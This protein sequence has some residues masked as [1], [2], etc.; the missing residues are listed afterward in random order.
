MLRLLTA[1]ATVLVS[2]A[3]AATVWLTACS[4]LPGGPNGTDTSTPVA[5]TLFKRDN[6]PHNS[7]NTVAS[8]AIVPSAF[9][10]AVG[11][12]ATLTVEARNSTG[13]LVTSVAPTWSSSDPT[14]ASVTNGVVQGV[15]TG[16]ALITASSAGVSDT[17]TATVSAAALPV[18]AMEMSPTTAAVIVGQSMPLEASPVAADSSTL[19]GQTITWSSSNS[20]VAAVSSAGAVTGVA[21][22]TAEVQATSSGVSGTV[23]VTVSPVPAVPVA[24]VT[25]T[26]PSATVVTGATV[27]LT[28]ATLDANG[29]ALSGRAVTW[30]SSDQNILT[31]STAGLVKGVA[32]GSATVTATS[33]GQTG[34]STIQVNPSV[35]AV[36]SVALSSTSAS[37]TA[38]QSVQLVVTAKDA[39]GNVLTGRTAS[40]TSSNASVAT[41]S[42]SGLVSALGAGSA[43]ITVT[44]E[45]RSATAAV[46]VTSSTT[47][48]P[49]TTRVGYY[50]APNGSSGGN[51][52]ISSPWDLASVLSG[53]KGVSAGDT[54]WVRGGTYRGQ[55]VNYM[56]GNT[57]QQI[58]VRQYPRERATI[59]GTLLV[60]GS[61][62]S[63]WGLEVMS[64]NP[65]G[66]GSLGVNMKAPG[67]RLINMVIHDAGVSGVGAWN[68]AP[69]AEVYGSLVY[70]NGTHANLDHGVYFNGSS[71]TKYITD[72]IVFDN[73]AYG[74]HAYSS[75]SGELSNLRLD[76][77]VSFNNGSIGPYCHSTDVYVGGSTITNLYV[78]RNMTW[79]PNDGEI[80]MWL[81]DGPGGQGFTYTGNYTVGTTLTGSFSGVTQSG[82]TAWSATSRPTSGLS[83][84]VRP[85]RYE[86]GRA[87][88]IVYNWG[89]QGSASADLSGVLRSGDTYE[90]RDAQAFFG[91]PVAQGTFNG[92]SITLPMTAVTPPAPIGRSGNTP[93]STGTQFHVFVV[94][95]T[96]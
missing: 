40:W 68:E 90:V 30:T 53:N 23:A 54:V 1:R 34:T 15:K 27:Q 20:A 80:T 88:I 12:P 8:V 50:V 32:A 51:G 31:V 81:G 44:I 56:N 29:A 24:S 74:L 25:L 7:R 65:T 63:F 9:T 93:T 21:P 72:N 69:N 19:A 87:N 49:P 2:A 36:A 52:S 43:T 95:K 3:V 4:D 48:P 92:G 35:I 57:S 59:D 77:N 13:R 86:A 83:V 85:N 70:N 28:A 6:L 96:N 17:A 22:G 75:T 82:N 55:F 42:S 91:S 10:I 18:V 78:N 84:I 47:P 37:L 61:Y 76:G 71:G 89:N 11:Q 16:V 73:W 33:E 38:G 60:M 41:V 39:A 62:V 66:S 5:E 26:P 64:S 94:L 67:S 14:V 79:R 58:V 46:T 45:G